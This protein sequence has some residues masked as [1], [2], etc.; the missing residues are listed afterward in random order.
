MGRERGSLLGGEGTGGVSS[1]EEVEFGGLLQLLDRVGGLFHRRAGD[2]GPV[3]GEEEGVVGAGRPFGERFE[4]AVT[5]GVVGEE[6]ELSDAHGVIG[7]ERGQRVGR[8][9]VVEAGDGGG[10]VECRWT[11]A[12]APGRAR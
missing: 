3:V 10:V 11:T 6:G 9:H 7:G 12:W 8:V 5:W 2:D 4:A 1:Q